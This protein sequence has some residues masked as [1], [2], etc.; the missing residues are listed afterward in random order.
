MGLCE[1]REHMLREHRMLRRRLHEMEALA[2]SVAAGRATLFPFLCVHGLDLLEAL[3]VQ[4]I[5]QEQ[6]LLPAIRDLYGP[7]HAERAACDQ[8]S[9]RDLLRFQLEELTDRANPPVSIAYGLRDLATIVHEQLEQQEQL[10]FAPDPLRDDDVF[11]KIET[12]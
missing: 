2:I 3:E 11:A 10:L 7:E 9:Q 1:V 5:W 4:R 12:A 8:R 6:S